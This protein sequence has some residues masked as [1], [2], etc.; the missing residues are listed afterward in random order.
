MQDLSTSAP[1]LNEQCDEG[2]VEGTAILS[3]PVAGMS[4]L[5]CEV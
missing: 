4:L 5:L 2:K 1:G 3:M